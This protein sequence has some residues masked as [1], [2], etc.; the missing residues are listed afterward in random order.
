[1]KHSLEHRTK[2]TP[3][4]LARRWGVSTTKIVNFIKSGE[5]RAINIAAHRKNRPRYLIDVADIAA[6]EKSR[7]VVPDTGPRT[8][9]ILRP[10]RTGNVREFF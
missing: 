4:D 1:V 3:P 10:R 6:F 8:A 5:L 9:N 7:S 2:L